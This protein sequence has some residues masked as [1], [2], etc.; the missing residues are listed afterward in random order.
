MILK[1]HDHPDGIELTVDNTVEISPCTTRKMT[2]EEWD[3]Y[4][5][6]NPVDRSRL[7]PDIR[8]NAWMPSEAEIEFVKQMKTERI[9]RGMSQDKLGKLVGVTGATIGNWEAFT[10]PVNKLVAVKIRQVLGLSD[11]SGTDQFYQGQ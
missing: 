8:W 10:W 6:L 9:R 5:E 7:K 11:M 4:G 1:N 3:K 2:P